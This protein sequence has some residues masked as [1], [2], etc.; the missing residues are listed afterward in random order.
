MSSF[1]IRR[2]LLT[3]V[4]TAVAFTSPLVM[5]H[6][7]ADGATHLHDDS[8]LRSLMDGA[9][10]P[11][12][13]LDHLAAM[14]SVGAWSTLNPRNAVSGRHLLAAP[15]AFAATLL[16]GAL[17]GLAGLQLPVVEPMIAA[18]LLVLGLLVASRT[19]LPTG[20]GA[21]LVAL[22]ALFHGLAHGAELGGHAMAALLGMVGC[23]VALHAS[24][25][26]LGHAMRQ[27]RVS[28]WSTRLAGLGVAL[29][30]GSLLAPMVAT[31]L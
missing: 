11:L 18:S 25:M 16:V 9:L 2:T 19:A 17:A 1:P 15:A 5:A 6:V 8:A 22:F 30:G 21:A 4:A 31:A 7:G 24:G 27:S 3:M 29:F 14:L 23:T 10:H 26:A 28:R 12:T 13:G 20:L